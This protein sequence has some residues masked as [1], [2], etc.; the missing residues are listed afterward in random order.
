[1]RGIAGAAALALA[2]GG[3]GAETWSLVP[4]VDATV[5]PTEDQAG[6]PEDA[7]PETSMRFGCTTDLDCVVLNRH[8]DTLNHACVQCVQHSDCQQQTQ[9]PWCSPL[10]HQCV[11]C[12]SF[13]TDTCGPDQ[14][15]QGIRC[16]YLC[17]DGGNCPSF[18]PFCNTSQ[19]R[20][21][22]AACRNNCD[23]SDAAVQGVCDPGLGECNPDQT[24]IRQPCTDGGASLD[25][26]DA[27][28]AGDAAMDVAIGDAADAGD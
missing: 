8:C 19:S 6:G 26:G 10:L 9:L 28:D 23:C 21:V 12:L 15:C 11:A 3:C 27:G 17:P 2:L 1:V 18:K 14:G 25:A 4:L 22:C 16:F 7:G 24:I 20:F 5:A 13:P